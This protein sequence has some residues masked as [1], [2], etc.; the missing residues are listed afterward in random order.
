MLFIKLTAQ[1]KHMWKHSKY[2][3]QAHGLLCLELAEA[4]TEKTPQQ[5]DFE[6]SIHEEKNVFKVGFVFVIKLNNI[7]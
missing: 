4:E 3:I 7:L 2:L 6:V 1:E 5:G